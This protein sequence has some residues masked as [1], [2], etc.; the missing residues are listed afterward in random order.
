MFLLHT[1]NPL[2]TQALDKHLRSERGIDKPFGG[3][4][5]FFIG[6]ALQMPQLQQRILGLD[7]V[8]RLNVLP[9][10]PDLPWLAKVFNDPRCR[11]KKVRQNF[12][13]FD[14]LT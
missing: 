13:L 2:Q 14:H 4:V 9:S 6:N 12:C 7:N 1:S 8:G 5:V 3:L 11:I 10:Y